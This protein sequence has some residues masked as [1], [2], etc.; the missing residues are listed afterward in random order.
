MQIQ[1]NLEVSDQLLR[2][3]L[4][5]AAEG[6]SNYWADFKCTA[7]HRTEHGAEWEQAQVTDNG[8][9][10]GTQETKTIGLHELREGMRIMLE[11][12]KCADQYKGHL[13]QAIIND[14]A[15]YID[16]EVADLVLQAV[17]FDGEVVYG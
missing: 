10:D 12:G 16:A 14:D 4:C 5:T 6:G 17:F 3:T 7:M 15:G 2:D 13:L 11:R 1:V 8:D 9:G